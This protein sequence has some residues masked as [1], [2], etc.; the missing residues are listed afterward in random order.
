MPFP[1]LISAFLH[2]G[3][4]PTSADSAALLADDP[5]VR[6]QAGGHAD[7]GIHRVSSSNSDNVER[8]QQRQQQHSSVLASKGRI[9]AGVGKRV[10]DRQQVLFQGR[11]QQVGF[12]NLLHYACPLVHSV[13]DHFHYHYQY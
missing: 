6:R 3:P 1:V 7:G 12:K 9:D 13:K 10:Q 4:V 2:R 5:A 11:E 8:R